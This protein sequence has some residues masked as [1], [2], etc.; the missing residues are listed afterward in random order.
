MRSIRV[1]AFVFL[2]ASL[3]LAQ[4]P[5]VD[6]G[7][8]GN[9]TALLTTLTPGSLVSIYGKELAAAFTAP[10]TIP[11]SNAIAGVTVTFNNVIAP[12]LFVAPGQI[13]AQLPFNVL[14]DGVTSGRVNLVVTRSGVSSPPEPVQIGPFSPGIFSIPAFAGYAIAITLQGEI[15]A[16]ANAI[17]GYPTRPARTGDTLQILANGLGAVDGPVTN[18]APPTALRQTTT[19][20]NVLVGGVSVTPGFSGLSPQFPGVNQV[21]I[22]V[23]AAAPRG[24]SV[25]L[26]FQVGGLTSTDKVVIAIQ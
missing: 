25:P 15:A 19:V 3:A 4:T 11:Y 7:G 17:P 26:Q 5:V 1:C 21:N 2:A 24:N 18:G 20:P 16:P 13:N 23:P 12:L 6:S 9:A 14:P 22:Q 10:D 8:V